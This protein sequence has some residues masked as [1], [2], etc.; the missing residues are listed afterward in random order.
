VDNDV[1]N[2]EDV[3]AGIEIVST[4][5]EDPEQITDDRLQS[6]DDGQMSLF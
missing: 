3:L 2:A 6:T 5:P 4:Q 1:V